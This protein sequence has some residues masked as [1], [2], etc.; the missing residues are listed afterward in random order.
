MLNKPKIKSTFAL[1]LLLLG[2]LNLSACKKSLY[3]NTEEFPNNNWKK[4]KIVTFK[5]TIEDISKPVRLKLLLR[6][7]V[8]IPYTSI[9][10]KFVR[11]NPNGTVKD[12]MYDFFIRDKATGA[13]KGDALGD[14]CD[15]EFI[16]FDK[17]QLTEKGTY[18]FTVEHMM[19]D[20]ILPAILDLGLE[21]EKVE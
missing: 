7:S 13:M 9:T 6:H 15:T 21:I 19:E 11:T 14:M 18:T 3:N 2:L 16:V 10:I 5:A 1:F 8:N 17:L 4:D 12:A 20:A